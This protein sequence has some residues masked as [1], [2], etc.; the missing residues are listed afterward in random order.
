MVCAW[1]GCGVD[2][3]AVY[4]VCEVWCVWYA[5]G[6]VCVYVCACRVMCMWCVCVHV[7]A[8][9]CASTWGRCP[10]MLSTLF[11]KTAESH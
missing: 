4:G 6:M 1:C 11:F 8:R 5:C 10:Q 9:A 2:I 7:C 3:G